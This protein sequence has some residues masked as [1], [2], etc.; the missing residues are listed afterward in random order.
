MKGYGQRNRNIA[1]GLG[2]NTY[3][4]AT[5]TNYIKKESL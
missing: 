1:M 5:I 4:A 2:S 3:A